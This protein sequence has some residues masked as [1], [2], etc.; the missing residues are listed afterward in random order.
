MGLNHVYRCKVCYHATISDNPIQ[1]CIHCGSLVELKPVKHIINPFP[2]S[3]N[4]PKKSE[5]EIEIWVSH[6]YFKEQIF[7]DGV[8]TIQLRKILQDFQD[9]ILGEEK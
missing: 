2:M 7:F 6:E 9:W 8:N 4:K 5:A 3:V 1:V